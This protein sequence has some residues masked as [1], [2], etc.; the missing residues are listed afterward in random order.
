MNKRILAAGAALAGLLSGTAC[1]DSLASD[2]G[3]ASAALEKICPGLI[4]ADAKLKAKLDK[5]YR[6]TADFKDGYDWVANRRS[7][8]TYGFGPDF[9]TWQ[10]CA[11]T[12][13]TKAKWLRMDPKTLDGLE[14]KANQE[15]AK[16]KQEEERH[17]KNCYGA[18]S[19]EDKIKFADEYFRRHPGADGMPLEYIDQFNQ[20]ALTLDHGCP[21]VTEF[22]N[23]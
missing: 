14:A 6:R 16:R 3:Y 11:S 9:V 19:L 12:A 22:W 18:L 13:V 4:V 21:T 15:E 2:F 5:K 8:T 23:H 10:I 20:S 1:A 7:E 17:P